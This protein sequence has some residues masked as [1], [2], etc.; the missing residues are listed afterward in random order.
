MKLFSILLVIFLA[1]LILSSSKKEERTNYKQPILFCAPNFDPSAINSDA[2]LLKDLVK[3]KYQVTTSSEKAQQYFNQGLALIYGFNHGEAAR[4]FNTAIKID[5]SFAMAYWGLAMVLGPNYNAALNPTSLTD[6]NDAVDNAVKYA[7]QAKPNEKALIHALSKRFPREEV[8]DMSGFYE[9]YSN[10]MKEAHQQFP[11]DVEIAVIY[12]DALMN[13]H[14]WNLWLKDGNAQPWTPGIVALLEKTLARWPDHQGAIHYYIHATEASKDAGKALVFAERLNKMTPVTGHL[15]HMP[16]HTYIRTGDYHKGVLVNEKASMV[17]SSYIAQC[18]VQG[19]YPMMYYP[20]NIHF[21][22][23]CAFLEGNSRKALDA[24]LKVSANA[25]K[26]FILENVSVQ[27]FN[28][29]PFYVMVHLAKWKDILQLEAPDERMKYPKG[30][31]HYARGMT[32]TATKDYQS[33]KKEL[34]SLKII[35]ADPELKNLMI[36]DMNSAADLVNIAA[37]TL[38][39]ELLAFNKNYDAAFS[40]FKKAITI[41]DGLNYNEPPDWFFSVRLSLGHWLVQAKKFKEAEKIYQEDL[42]T[43]PENG[44]ALI[45]LYNSLVGQ[46]R[47]EDAL[48]VKKRFEKAWKWSDLKIKSSRIY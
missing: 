17:D 33:A 42:M 24:A 1:G 38:E 16:S 18:K 10:A 48:K 13:L 45:G 11:D 9:A 25:D 39:G 26:K 8:K 4:S 46:G 30:I 23:A 20:H 5:S 2:P 47:S 6:I 22:A 29:I 7:G 27:H 28:I 43:F 44:W 14:P 36:W 41:E 3:T 37:F 35:A 34:E 40:S 12:A 15:V 31:W 21:L 32:F 19:V